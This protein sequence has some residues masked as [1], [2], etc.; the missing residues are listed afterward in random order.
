MS[1]SHLSEQQFEGTP[2]SAEQEKLLDTALQDSD[3][4][5]ARSL[6]G[7]QQRRT[8]RL[9]SLILLLGGVVMSLLLIVMLVGFFTL[10][11]P[12]TAQSIADTQQAEELTAAGWKLWGSRQYD[13]A[14]A[15]F[16]QAVKLDPQTVHAWN[17]L[18]WSHFNS[19]QSEKAIPAFE[20][21]V[22]L[23]PD[24]AGAL[25]G[26]GQIYLTWKDYPYAEK[27]LLMSAKSPGAS[28]SWYG[29]ARV[30]L[31]QEEFAKAKPWIKKLLKESPDRADAKEMLAAAEAGELSDSLRSKLEPPGK[32]K[33]ADADVTRGWA[34]FQQGKNRTAERLFRRALEKDEANLA[35]LN[36]LGF[37]LLNQGRHEQAQPMFEKYLSIQK[38][39]PGPMNGLARCY[40]ASGK[41][42]QAIEIWEKMTKKYPG[43]SAGTSGL[44]F[45]Y[46]EQEQYSKAEKYFAILVKADPENN[47]F[48]RGLERAQAGASG[49]R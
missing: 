44:A 27:Y 31:L 17:G 46:L 18:G 39:A 32:A 14:A 33:K 23:Q 3:Q 42:D 19:G 38:D 5:L 22:A 13:Q 49:D 6:L 48:Q 40:Q 37:S 15:K 11:E 12:G 25:N 43:P 30:Y 24:H 41:V 35:A 34:L 1:D 26:L 47:Q 4:L 20:K 45:A 10:A 29:L 16:E 9:W 7:D 28:A 2:L 21:C 8:R 36:G